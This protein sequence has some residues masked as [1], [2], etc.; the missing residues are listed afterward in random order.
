[1]RK[2]ALAAALPLFLATA[3]ASAHFGLTAPPST[4]PADENGKGAP[5]CGPDT[6]QAGTP[7]EAQGG[8]D[9]NL[10]LH[11]TVPHDG[12]YRVALSLKPLSEIYAGGKTPTQGMFFPVDNIV[13]D[14]DGNILPPDHTTG[15][16][17]ASAEFST[18]PVFPVLADNLFPHTGT[19]MN[20][21]LGKVKLPNVNCERCTLQVIEF[22][23]GH[24]YNTGGGYF[25]HHCAELKI[26]ADP[27]MPIFDPNNQGGGGAGGGGGT[28]GS[29]GTAGAATAGGGAGGAGSGSGGVATSGSGGAGISGSAT[30]AGATTGGVATTAAGSGGTGTTTN[31][32][33]GSSSDDGSCGIANRGPGGASLLAALGLAYALVRRRRAR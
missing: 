9:L 16:Q 30:T 15:V 33:S 8:H 27:A 22:M 13:K 17:S 11:E 18:N 10:S 21:W 26:T 20:P 31:A 14:K 5:P 4:K 7:T 3:T 12:F 2:L 28:G 6:A 1:M 19:P 25:Y 29:T 32:G 23:A 24:G